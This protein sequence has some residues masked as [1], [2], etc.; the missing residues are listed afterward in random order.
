MLKSLTSMFVGK[1]S[2]TDMGDRYPL[3]D[4]HGQSNIEGL[5]VVGDIS[6]TPDI[7]AAINGG[8]ELA[9]HLASLPR[10]PDGRADCEILIIGGGPAG[11]TV[12]L[13]L[14]K[15][16]IPYLLLERKRLFNSVATLGNKRKLFLAETGPA[17]VRGDLDFRDC[18]VG[19]CLSEWERVVQEYEL[20]V[21]L[22]ATVT[23]INKR[24]LFEVVTPQKTY[25]AHR[26]VVAIGK[27]TFLGKIDPASEK[28]PNLRY[29]LDEPDVQMSGKRLLVIG[30][31]ACSLS[32]ETACKMAGE[33]EVTLACEESHEH[34]GETEIDCGCLDVKMAGT[35][36]F[37]PSTRVT[38]IRGGDVT[39][40]TPQGERNLSF[41]Y[42]LPMTRF[43]QEVP[44][45]TLR[46]FGLKYEN[47]WERRRLFTFI[48]V[49]LLVAAFYT[50]LKFWGYEFRW[51][52]FYVGEFYPILYS[53][54]VVG[55]G[56]KA[57]HKY[58]T[59]YHDKSQITRYLSLMFFQVVLFTVLP[60]FVIRSG[61]SWGLVYVWPLSV[62]PGNWADWAQ[63]KQFYLGWVMFITLIGLPVFV[64]FRGKSY[65]SWVCGC[66]ALAET[67]GDRWRHY[68]PKGKANTAREKQ[69]A[70]VTGFAVVAT[71]LIAFGIDHLGAGIS[72]SGIY[73]YTVDL[74]LIAILPIAFYPFF[75]GKIWCRYWCPAVGL[76]NLF[77]RIKPPSLAAH[78]IVSRKE[79]C[80]ACG[81]CDRYCEVGVPVK[82]FALKGKG[83]DMSNTSC[84]SCGICI[85]V[86][87]TRVLSYS[88]VTPVEIHIDIPANNRDRAPS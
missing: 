83:F 2:F 7:K 34:A 9:D 29:L 12:A 38:A 18:T 60:I 62:R 65:C 11:F 58:A 82:S 66:G 37:L 59:V 21:E 70:Y 67:V 88:T 72:L 33:N 25:L 41:D 6:A 4:R 80:I 16:G 69:L 31:D 40:D 81:M 48:P 61:G 32:F 63:T 79:R 77:Q 15:R 42:I 54:L 71:L 13:E 76:M 64:W 3:L 53:L 20:N 26:V 85:S 36:T 75:G 84:I 5:W 35:I 74:A 43:E 50:S 39:M 51:L 28:N 57:M 10:T 1:G 52:G 23:K 24:D 8:V 22:G 78:A 46:N 45:D 68:S 55:F 44:V 27:L 49:L 19:D 47:R 14:H 56:I 17:G 87:P 73:D 86:C 30:S